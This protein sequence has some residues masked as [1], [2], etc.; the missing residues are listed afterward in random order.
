[1]FTSVSADGYD[2]T[3]V[4]PSGDVITVTEYENGRIVVDYYSQNNHIEY[5][6]FLDEVFDVDT[7]ET[8][9]TTYEIVAGVNMLG[10]QIEEIKW[11]SGKKIEGLLFKFRNK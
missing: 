11:N 3:I 5:D 2:N 7:R 10:L 8:L 9:A 6:S 4:L 1:M